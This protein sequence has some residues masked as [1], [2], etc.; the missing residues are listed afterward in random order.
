MLVVSEEPTRKLVERL[1]KGR[2]RSHGS[3]RQPWPLAASD[4][5][6]GLRPG[7]ALNDLTGVVRQVNA[8]IADVI[9]KEA[10][11]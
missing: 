6:Y 10:G 8:A 9:Q 11:S 3:V 1:K 4:R 5:T 7:R 2:N